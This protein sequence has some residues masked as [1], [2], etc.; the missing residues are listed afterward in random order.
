MITRIL[1]HS[2][3][4]LKGLLFDCHH[5]GQCVL[6]STRLICPMRC[7]KQLRNGPCGGTTD[8]RCEVHPDRLCIWVRIQGRRHGERIETPSSL[9]AVDERLRDTPSWVNHCTGADR[10]ARTP[11]M[12]VP[13]Q[14]PTEVAEPA[15]G[16]AL[17]A[18][19]RS[20]EFVCT[21][22]VRAPRGLA[23]G[24]LRRQVAT[25]RD[26]VAA[27]N[28][29]AHLNGAPSL[30]PAEVVQVL[31]ELGCPSIGQATA[32]D[33]TATSFLGECLA[34]RR[35][36]CRNLLC[37]TGDWAAEPQRSHQVFGM[38]SSL[39]LREAHAAQAAAPPAE[40][41]F[42]GAAI[43]PGSS[44]WQ[45]PIRRLLQK[46]EAGARFIQT[47][48]VCDLDAFATFMQRVV[49]Q[50]LH[51]RLFLLAGV[52]VVT[53][54][55]ALEFLPRITGVVCPPAFHEAL[56]TAPDIRAAGIAGASAALRRL[57][58]MP[59]VHGAHLML[60][61]PDHSAVVETIRRGIARPSHKEFPACPTSA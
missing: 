53:S 38:D 46:A 57:Q 58:T 26:E 21:S 29:T 44:P 23:C 31:E 22:E 52:P 47:Q 45:V 51:R 48:L 61:G 2:E 6:T 10:A 43:N 55:R 40:R 12:P 24:A 9:P 18:R 3:G 16:S 36:G 37:L 14:P 49:E 60:F 41:L 8:G 15:T 25:L 56:A 4:L 33:H 17:E 19:L 11:L 30:P 5:C 20:G 39:M 34:L 50:G 54:R 59:G 27:L 13:E 42:L 35:H 7:P 32:R 28:C 1:H